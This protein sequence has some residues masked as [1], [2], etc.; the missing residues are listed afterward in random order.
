M[1]FQVAAN[2]LFRKEKNFCSVA[3]PDRFVTSYDSL[4]LRNY[5]N[6]ALKSNRQ[7]NF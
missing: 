7:K 2:N 5:M 1:S 3:D 4:S 6:I